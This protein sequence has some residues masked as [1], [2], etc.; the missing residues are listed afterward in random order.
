[1]TKTDI[2]KNVNDLTELVFSLKMQK[3][4]ITVEDFEKRTEQLYSKLKQLRAAL[5]K[6]M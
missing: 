1:M 6:E 5:E 3:K 2:L 4:V